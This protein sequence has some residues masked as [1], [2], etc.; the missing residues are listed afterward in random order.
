ML[1]KNV[2][3]TTNLKGFIILSK[4]NRK[5]KCWLCTFLQTADNFQHFDFISSQH[6]DYV[7]LGL[8]TKPL[9]KSWEKFLFLY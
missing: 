1:L 7:W 6:R 9:G 3:I 4:T 5:T 2:S 8:G